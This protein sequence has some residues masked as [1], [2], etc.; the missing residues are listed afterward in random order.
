M[1][2]GSIFAQHVPGGTPGGGG[3]SA[4]WASNGYIW[5]S[6]IV[7]AGERIPGITDLSGFLFRYQTTLNSLKTEANGGNV[8]SSSGW[9]IRFEDDNGVKLP[10]RFLTAYSATTGAVDILI[11][12]PTVKAVGE[13]IIYKFTGKT[14]TAT[15]EDIDGVY[16][17]YLDCWDCRTGESLKDV[18]ARDMTVKDTLSAQTIVGDGAN[19]ALG[20]LQSAETAWFTG[21]SAM[22]MQAVVSVA[23]GA[24]GTDKGVLAQGALDGVAG[25]HGF[26]LQLQATGKR[27]GKANVVAGVITTS[28]GSVVVESAA[29]SHQ[30]GT[31]YWAMIYEAGQLGRLNINGVDTV[32]TWA[33]SVVGSTVTPGGVLSGTTAAKS[34]NFYIGYGPDGSAT[35]GAVTSAQIRAS[36]RTNVPWLPV[37]DDDI[38]VLDVPASGLSTQSGSAADKALAAGQA[39]KVALLVPPADGII[40]GVLNFRNC[41]WAGIILVGAVLRPNATGTTTTPQ[42]ATVGISNVLW[43]ST[44]AD[45]ATGEG[46]PYF[47]VANTEVDLANTDVGDFLKFGGVGTNRANYPDLIFQRLKFTKGHYGLNPDQ[48]HSDVFQA[49]LGNGTFNTLLCYDTDI[50]WRYQVFFHRPETGS[51]IIGTTTYIHGVTVRPMPFSSAFN[52]GT[53]SV[54]FNKIC[55]FIDGGTTDY[56]A[57]AYMAWNFEDC[58]AVRD[59]NARTSTNTIPADTG[60]FDNAGVS[61]SVSNSVVSWD[62]PAKDPPNPLAPVTGTW[63]FVDSDNTDASGGKFGK[64]YRIAT[65]AKLREVTGT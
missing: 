2:F 34:G 40:S 53:H 39:G 46:R 9:D 45:S 62:T 59:P 10:H 19:H 52:T 47:F 27:G 50:K 18:A 57:G 61:A 22:T 28:A 20:Y 64:N 21:H 55:D 49:S 29:N 16:A 12:L 4:T 5:R 42:N 14:L 44:T 24:V 35:S 6:P 17:D 37:D 48:F 56:N 1:G 30:T 33:G 13:T 51:D 60:Y 38:V 23:S 54:N 31:R 32:P 43:Y 65:V 63:T 8:K 41:K 26:G 11:R 7:I 58:I 25:N 36:W 15:E 3:S